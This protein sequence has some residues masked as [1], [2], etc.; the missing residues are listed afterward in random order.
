MQLPARASTIGGLIGALVVD[1]GVQ[2]SLQSK[3]DAATNG[4]APMCNVLRA[5]RNEIDA[6][7]GKKI[8]IDVATRLLDAIDVARLNCP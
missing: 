5:A 4:G 7:S 3:L 6:Q 2:G 8:P 1:P